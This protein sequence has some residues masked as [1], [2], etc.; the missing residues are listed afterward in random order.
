MST[1]SVNIIEITEIR[2]HPKADRL[3]IVPIGGWQAVVGKGQFRPGDRAVYIEPDYT[4]PLDV[5]EFAFLKRPEFP[6]DERRRLHA[7]RLRGVLSYGLLIPVPKFLRNRPLGT[8]VML[9]LGIERYEPALT[10]ADDLP[11]DLWPRTFSSKFDVESVQNFGDVIRDGEIV[12]VTEK[13][14]GGSARYLFSEGV[15]Y[16][17]SRSNWLKPEGNHPWKLASDQDPSI[18]AWCERNEDRI[19]YG[20]VYGAV[21]S[22]RYGA[23]VGEIRFS[24]FAS[25]KMGEWENTM[26]LLLDPTI[27]TAPLIYHGPMS[28]AVFALAEEDSTVHGAPAGHMREGIVIVPEVERRDLTL[29][30]V[31][32]KHISNRY[33]EK[34]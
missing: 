3:E 2:P 16:M 5:P 1:H 17:G 18:R 8:D 27:S 6:D 29:G 15:F 13:I 32:V 31:A 9:D 22:L 19:L 21:Q 4:V 20:E 11:F 25:M 24:A 34:G 14:H 30:R 28:P 33:W 10:S 23:G 12:I 7:V 26:P